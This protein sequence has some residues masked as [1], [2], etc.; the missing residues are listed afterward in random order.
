MRSSRTL[1]AAIAAG[2]FLVPTGAALAA[3]DPG[4]TPSS[5][6]G[7]AARVSG[8]AVTVS[9]AAAF[10]GESPVVVG[11]DNAGDGPTHAVNAQI[12]TATGVDLL[13][14]DVSQPDP[15]KQQLVFRWH[16]AGLPQTGAVPEI[17]FY[18]WGLQVNGTTNYVLQAKFSNVLSLTWLDDQS[19]PPTHIGGTFQLRGGCGP[20]TVGGQQLPLNNC[21]SLAFLTGGFDPATNTVKFVL[22]L[23]QSYDKDIVPGAVLTPFNYDTQPIVAGYGVL[24]AN[25]NT[26]DG[27]D[28]DT[29]AVPQYVIP[30]PAVSLAIAPAGTAPSAVTFSTAATLAADGSFTGSL[31]TTGLAHGA[32]AVFAKAC[33]GANCG[34]AQVPIT[35]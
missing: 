28:W 2:L 5:V 24:A 12:D 19:G 33:F 30:S 7:L 35:L 16:V 4:P 1:I 34:V 22:P 26:E 6:S 31:A 10:G 15:A 11:T 9:G 13:S 17:T 25:A 3:G 18:R 29:D 27:M 32:Y 23:G 20:Q 21:H 8:A 14:A